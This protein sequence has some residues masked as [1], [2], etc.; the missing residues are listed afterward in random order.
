MDSNRDG[1]QLHH[2]HQESCEPFAAEF[3]QRL[4]ADRHQSAW[5]PAFGLLQHLQLDMKRAGWWW[6]QVFQVLK[7]KGTVGV[8]SFLWPDA[9]LKTV[10]R[11]DHRVYYER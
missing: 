6:P 9:V 10:E 4:G 7:W 2:F 5:Q 3:L 11:S 8:S 1:L